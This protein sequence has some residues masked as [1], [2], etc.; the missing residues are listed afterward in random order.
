MTE[1]QIGERC[2]CR[3]VNLSR[4]LGQY[5]SRPRYDENVIQALKHLSDQH[6]RWGFHKMIAWLQNQGQP[7]NHKRGYRVYCAI[8]LNLRISK[9]LPKRFPEPLTEPDA[10]NIC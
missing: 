10:L 4:S 2:A 3:I 5:Q 6:P 7:W 1:H 8:K 9:R